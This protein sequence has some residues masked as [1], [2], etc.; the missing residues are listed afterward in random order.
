MKGFIDV[1]VDMQEADNNHSSSSLT[2]L[3]L[4]VG[5]VKR[6]DQWIVKQCQAAICNE[7]NSCST[8]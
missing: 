6:V 1:Y 4:I 5:C 2:Y 8:E 3:E 7:R